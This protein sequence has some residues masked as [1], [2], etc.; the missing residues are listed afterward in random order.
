[1]GIESILN[2]SLTGLSTSLRALNTT[3]SNVANV[4]TPDYVRRV[5]QQE[6]LVLAGQVSGVKIGEV[7]RI[8][9]EFLSK[10]LRLARADAG[11]YEAMTIIH[12][13]LQSFLGSPNQNITVPGRLD[14]A[15]NSFADLVPEPDSTVRRLTLVDDLQ[16]YAN[17]VTRIGDHLQLLR[18]ESDRRIGE[19]I[20]TINTALTRLAELNPRIAQT[21][22]SDEDPTA[23]EE[24]RTQALS[25]I[26]ELIAIR[27]TDLD[28]GFQ[29]VTTTTGLVLLDSIRRELVY[30][31]EGTVTP[32]TRFSQI[33]ANKVDSVTGQAAAT[34]KALDPDINSGQLRGLIDMRNT[35]LPNMAL[36][37]GELSARVVDEL[38][39][40]HN[41]N[42]AVPPPSSLTGRAT[43]LLGTDAH[44]FTGTATFVVTD[45][46]EEITRRIDIDFSAN[47]ID[48]DSGGTLADV[49]GDI[50]TALGAGRTFSLSSTG[51]ITFSTANAGEG[52][53][54]VQGT[55]GSDRGGRGF[56]HHFG[57]NDLMTATAESNFDTGFTTASAHGFGATGIVQIEFRGPSGEL[58]Q[59]FSLDFSAVGGTAFSDVLSSLNTG[60]SGV[61]SFSL[62]SNGALVLTPASGFEDYTT[63]IVSDTTD[64]GSTGKAFSD[65][66]GLGERFLMNAAR[67]V[68]VVDRI[69][70]DPKL[71]ALAD[72]DLAAATGVPALTQG[73]NRGAI[74]LQNVAEA[75]V[76][77]GAAGDIAATTT[78]LNAFAANVLS[79]MSTRAATA[80][81]IGNDREAL[82]DTLAIRV[83]EVSGVNLDEELANM[84]L[85]QNAYTA[86]ARLITTA[87]ELFDTLIEIAG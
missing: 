43:G 36:E 26:G 58:G 59:S 22:A 24:Q 85:F 28:N 60:F 14:I 61:A 62:D 20:D 69:T 57:M 55:T 52:V 63:F 64:R 86:S 6:S 9:D 33:T 65:L 25:E 84:I 40:V 27:T 71:L 66:F 23:L 68:K 47:T 50:N 78:S 44:G 83:S 53:A 29:H 80:E 15:F 81:S 42:S 8:T 3:S 46:N 51:A 87:Q 39:R 49:V 75:S 56:A 37:L 48:I 76:S 35:V 10:E 2:T 77:F 72:V 82:K 21:F 45:T 18:Q 16:A 4:N 13:R 17:E 73:D 7:R 19:A 34:G 11:R 74:A 30:T 67:G 5:V 54:V 79:Q 1:M 38:N 31:P 32:N 12:E 70:T 41:D